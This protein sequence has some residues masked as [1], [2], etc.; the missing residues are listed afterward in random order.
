MQERRV[1]LGKLH[2]NYK[3]VGEGKTAVVLLHGWGLSSDR[4]VVTA[5]EILKLNPDFKFYILDLPGFGKS[6]EPETAWQLDDYV[7]AV[8]RFVHCVVWRRGGFE[9]VKSILEQAVLKSQIFSSNGNEPVIFLAHSFGGRITIKYAIR[10]PSDVSRIVMTG[11]AG[12]RH[13]LS[14]KKKIL[15]MGAKFGKAIVRIPILSRYE[16][17]GKKMLYKLT[18]EKDYRESSEVMKGVMR[19]VLE[20]D[21]SGKLSEV[22]TSTLLIWGEDDRSTPLADGKLMDERIADSKLF[23]IAGANH[24][25]PYNNAREFAKIFTENI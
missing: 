1:K 9:Q 17:E 22:K 12:I 10:Y 11:A 14:A 19:N 5:E 2:I 4:Y 23:I 24:S 13:P 7:E 25:A 3:T 18:K 15:R 8:H 21:L 16:E 20:E 6:A